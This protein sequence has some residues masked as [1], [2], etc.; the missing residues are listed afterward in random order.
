MESI[1]QFAFRENKYT[2]SYIICDREYPTYIY[3]SLKN[4]ALVKEFGEE[5][6]IHCNGGEMLTNHIYSDTRITLYKA[7]FDA[8]SG[9][10]TLKENTEAAR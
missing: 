9:I 2:A 3:I 8:I 5:L 7:I 1:I 4:E 10:E 6:V